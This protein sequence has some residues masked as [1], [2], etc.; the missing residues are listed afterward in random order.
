M[1]LGMTDGIDDESEPAATS[2]LVARHQEATLI[3]AS[4]SVSADDC[5]D[6]R[7][8]RVLIGE[9]GRY[10][11]IIRG[12]DVHRTRCD[13]WSSFRP[14]SA[15]RRGLPPSIRP[16]IANGLLRRGP[17]AAGEQIGEAERHACSFTILLIPGV[18]LRKSEWALPLRSA[19]R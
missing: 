1:I 12:H 4:S 5:Y 19:D 2:V 15:W 18:S 10:D 11:D 6:L 17:L 7:H 16:G 8:P 13:P 3:L 9:D 14:R